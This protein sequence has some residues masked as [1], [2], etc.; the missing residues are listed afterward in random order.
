MPVTLRTLTDDEIPQAYREP[1]LAELYEVNDGEGE[2]H[3]LKSDADA[4]KLVVEL[5]EKHASA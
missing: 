5:T 1:D 2:V 4:A 3:Y